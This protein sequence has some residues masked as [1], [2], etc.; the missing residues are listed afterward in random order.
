[1]ILDWLVLKMDK[2]LYCVLVGSNLRLPWKREDTGTE[3]YGIVDFYILFI[4][5]CVGQL[6]DSSIL[7]QKNNNLVKTKPSYF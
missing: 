5:D 3:D 7:E 1:M 4:M 6:M 2:Y